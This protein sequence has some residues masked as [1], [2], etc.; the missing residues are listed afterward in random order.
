MLKKIAKNS[1]CVAVGTVAVTFIVFFVIAKCK[2]YY[3]TVDDYVISCLI[4]SGQNKILF[5]NYFLSSVLVWI[6]GIFEQVNVFFAFQWIV[7]FIALTGINFVFIKKFRNRPVFLM[8]VLLFFDVLF[9][10]P[11][12]ITLQYSQ[13]TAMGF[14]AGSLIMIYC[15]ECDSKNKYLMIFGMVFAV[16]SALFRIQAILPISAVFLLYI[17]SDIFT[18][19]VRQY[20]ENKDFVGIIKKNRKKY[21]K[22]I[23]LYVSVLLTVFLLT[24]SSDMLKRQ[25]SWY[26]EYENYN[27]ARTRAVDYLGVEYE[28]N[29][30]F[31]RSIGIVSANDLKTVKSWSIDSDFSTAER[32]NQM[33]DYASREEFHLRFSVSRLFD[34]VETRLSFLPVN[35]KIVLGMIALVGI[36][37]A[38]FLFKIRNSITYLFPTALLSVYVV[39]FVIFGTESPCFALMIPLAMLSVLTCFLF[40][41]YHYFP[42]LLI[43][44]FVILITAYQNFN[45]INFRVTFTYLIAS[46]SV[47]IFLIDGKNLRFGFQRMLVKLQRILYSIS[48]VLLCG[49]VAV[50][51]SGIIYGDGQRVLSATWNS[52]LYDYINKDKEHLY[53]TDETSVRKL[54]V[55]YLYPFISPDMLDNVLYTGWRVGD[56]TQNQVKEK[57]HVGCLYREMIERDDIYYAMAGS[58]K[59]R[60][61]EYFNFHYGDK[62]YKVVMTPYKDFE[63]CTVYSVNKVKY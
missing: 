49:T 1:L 48:V 41:R 7:N 8:V 2:V 6:Q 55:N 16:I 44:V 38:L 12:L 31:Y 46:F 4:H 43:N 39:F 60:M 24:V 9:I 21:L 40:N 19:I 30:E 45:R 50:S 42:Y 3:S 47:L 15:I 18:D 28:G 5:L 37:L 58:E 62:G 35:G 10:W 53:V 32:F 22:P 59:E 56:K 20:K 36:V 33:A 29:E 11:A 34:E 26:V 51:M 57:F 61:E 27:A 23:L 14:T 54:Y 13:T 25:D 52:D 17:F 63:N